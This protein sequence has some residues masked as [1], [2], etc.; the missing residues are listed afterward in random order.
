M[1]KLGLYLY[2][3]WLICLY[4]LPKRIIN[5]NKRIYRQAS[6]I[7][8]CNFSD[9]GWSQ[10]SCKYRHKD[11]KDIYRDKSA[12]FR[13]IEQADLLGCNLNWLLNGVGEM[14]SEVRTFKPRT[15]PVMVIAEVACG[16]PVHT[17]IIEE[18]VK[19]V[20]CLILED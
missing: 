19:C 8:W 12:G 3:K 5:E 6:G 14:A 13:G 18:G 2:I 17:Q 9:A 4:Q 11:C 15:K 10:R 20:V 7:L 16:I 1:L